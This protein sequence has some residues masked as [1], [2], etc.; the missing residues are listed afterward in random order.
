MAE[1]I[2]LLEDLPSFQR[3]FADRKANESFE[4]SLNTYRAFFAQFD[5]LICF[6]YIF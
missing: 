4:Q 6:L 1:K 3:W 2:K 5:Q